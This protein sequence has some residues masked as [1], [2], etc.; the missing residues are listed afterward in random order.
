MRVRRLLLSLSLAT[1][2]FAGLVG[3]AAAEPPSQ[4]QARCAGQFVSG[5]AGPG[6]GP[7]VV[8]G[9]QTGQLGQ[10]VSAIASAPVCPP[11]P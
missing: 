6:F 11:M 2:L 7:F 4:S 5:L 10:Q 1:A 9:A 8:A 3:G